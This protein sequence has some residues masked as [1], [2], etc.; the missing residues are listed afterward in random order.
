MINTLERA[1]EIFAEAMTS[2]SNVNRYGIK[3]CVMPVD[4]YLAHDLI[5]LYQW[6]T[7]IDNCSNTTS[8]DPS[9]TGT[10]TCS[11]QSIVERI[12]TL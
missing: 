1:N 12:N 3:S 8:V 11:L 9:C 7:Q 4:P 6:Y 2:V 10:I 5:E